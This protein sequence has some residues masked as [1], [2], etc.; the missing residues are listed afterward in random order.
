MQTSVYKI[1]YQTKKCIYRYVEKYM[2]TKVH[3]E[4][5]CMNYMT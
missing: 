2:K 5:V 4:Y 3:S 1:I